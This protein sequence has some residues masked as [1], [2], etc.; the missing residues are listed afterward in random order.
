M[1]DS[2]SEK[3]DIER[4]VDSPSTDAASHNK[5]EERRL[6]RKI[7]L[8]ILPASIIIYLLCFLDRSNIGNARLL[9][10]MT[11][12]S[13]M[14][15]LGLTNYQ[16]LIALQTFL[17]AY[18][19]FEIPSNYFLKIF[20]PSRWIALLMFLWGSMTMAL[21]G[22]QNYAGLTVVRFLL[23]AAEAGLF[24]GLV[25]L[26]TFWYRPEERSL[27]IALVWASATLAGAFGGAIAY[28][29]GH[30]NMVRGI[31]GW[32][33]LFILEVNCAGIPS[34]ASSLLVLLFFPD[35]PETAAWLSEEER[36]L[37]VGRLNG[38][39][40]TQSSRFTWAE[41]KATLKDWRLY[42]HYIGY[43]C[44]AIPL[45]SLS[46]FLP[47]IVSGLG[48]SGLEAQLFTVPPYACAYVVT[49]VCAWV[50]DQ[51]NIRSLI[52]TCCMFVASI[53]FLVEALL[54]AT[55]FKARYGVLCLATA[56]SFAC[57]APSLGWL[58]SNLHTTGAAGLALG[59]ALSF[60]GPG[61]IIGVWI[62]KSNESPR[63]F[64]GHM[65]NFAILL[66]GMCIFIGLR[67]LYAWR[68]RRLP[69]GSRLWVL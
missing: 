24:P 32:R 13:L 63:Y 57:V 37:V 14:K 44:T 54:P 17:I 18:T 23:G 39:A 61:Q 69:E 8:K 11:G 34:V 38:L 48:Y 68:N 6:V 19:V 15:T 30:M 45:S 10:D 2:S 4:Y 43:L 22:V 56:S 51:H 42:G 25:Y 28:G 65:V 26:F 36:A 49:L 5:A 64:T 33:W 62:Y 21:G 31:E 41:A 1:K 3:V 35:F 29:V 27:R 47:T 46:L 20:R 9:N 67:T 58:S 55:A 40:S 50:A 59:L 16:Y 12:H 52:S 7:D 60:A 66:L 53:S